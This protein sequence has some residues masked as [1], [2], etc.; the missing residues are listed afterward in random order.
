LRRRHFF[1]FEVRIRFDAVVRLDHERGAATARA[2][3]NADF[4]AARLEVRVDCGIRSDVSQIN[5]LRENG[6]HGR[7]PGVVNE[8]LNLDVRAE[9][10]LEPA[11]A[12][13]GQ[14][15]PNDTLRVR[16]VWEVAYAKDDLVRGLASR[17]EGA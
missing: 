15:M 9:A 8:P 17:A 2:R 11:F 16:D 1:A 3:N 12:L 7:W 6:L 13:T 14:T 4:L 5:G 10:L